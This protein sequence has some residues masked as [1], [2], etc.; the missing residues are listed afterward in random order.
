[1]LPPG[2]SFHD[3]YTNYNTIAISSSSPSPSLLSSD[4]RFPL[5]FQFLRSSALQR[6]LTRSAGCKVELC[7]THSSR[8]RVGYC[9][10]RL[11]PSPTGTFLQQH[12]RS[13]HDCR[14]PT[15][16]NKYA[17]TSNSPEDPVSLCLEGWEFR[18][19]WNIVI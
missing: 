17:S 7:L 12:Y 1:M 16:T 8:L 6:S 11:S 3:K 4:P 13:F 9:P 2:R 15:H 19:P 14:I 5:A 18:P 10:S